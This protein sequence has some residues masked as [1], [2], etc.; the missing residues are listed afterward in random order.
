MGLSLGLL[1]TT[2]FGAARIASS[3][4][5]CKELKEVINKIPVD[6]MLQ[7]YIIK[8]LL[9]SPDELERMNQTFKR[10]RGKGFKR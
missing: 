10:Y 7:K 8:P 6:T 4:I 5:G 2:T 3:T 9:D 1:T